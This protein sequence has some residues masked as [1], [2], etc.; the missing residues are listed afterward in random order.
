MKH[1]SNDIY[2]TEKH[3]TTYEVARL[4]HSLTKSKSSGSDN[5]STEHL[6]YDQSELLYSGPIVC[7][8]TFTLKYNLLEWYLESFSLG[9]NSCP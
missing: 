8:R 1:T 3:V 4:I 6:I 7:F 9:N 2:Y 5:I